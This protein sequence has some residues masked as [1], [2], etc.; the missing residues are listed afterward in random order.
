MDLAALIADVIQM[1]AERRIQSFMFPRLITELCKKAGVPEYL[2]DYKAK[3]DGPAFSAKTLVKFEGPSIFTFWAGL[4]DGS[5]TLPPIPPFGEAAGRKRVAQ[6]KKKKTPTKEKKKP[7]DEGSSKTDDD[8]AAR[9]GDEIADKSRPAAAE[10]EEGARGLP[11][12][13][14]EVQNNVEK[15]GGCELL[16]EIT[17][18]G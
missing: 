6:P 4:K 3:G 14:H 13:G 11:K 18:N 5:I 12:V 2:E 8:D 15:Y 7:A 1:P 10:S 17:Q 16:R 9:P